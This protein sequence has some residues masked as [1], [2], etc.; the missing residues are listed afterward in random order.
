MVSEHAYCVQ[1]SK[2]F[3]LETDNS[4]ITNTKVALKIENEKSN[5]P[6]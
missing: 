3:E 5:L 4:Q 6:K 2:I 1:N